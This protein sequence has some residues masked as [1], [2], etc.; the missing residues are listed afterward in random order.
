MELDRLSRDAIARR[1]ASL[2]YECMA[3]VVFAGNR[4]RVFIFPARFVHSRE[5][6][7]KR[8]RRVLVG[9]FV[10]SSHLEANV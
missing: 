1:E 9:G 3:E 8:R 4:R 5:R 7:R 6:S 2:E 10:Q